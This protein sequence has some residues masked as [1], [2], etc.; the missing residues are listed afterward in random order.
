M[1]LTFCPLNQRAEREATILPSWKQGTWVD[2]YELVSPLV[3]MSKTGETPMSIAGYAAHDPTQG[4]FVLLMTLDPAADEKTRQI[5]EQIEQ[6]RAVRHSAVQTVYDKIDHQGV[7]LYVMEGPDAM[8]CEEWRMPG[9]AAWAKSYRPE[10]HWRYEEQLLA[11]L[12]PVV[13][14]LAKLE[15]AS[16]T[17]PVRVA[18]DGSANG[19][20]S[21]GLIFDPV[22]GSVT[23]DERRTVLS[24][25]VVECLRT[26]GRQVD[27]FPSVQAAMRLGRTFTEMRDDLIRLTVEPDLLQWLREQGDPT[28]GSLGI[29]LER[30]FRRAAKYLP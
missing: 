19:R 28:P 12:L 22:E 14:A 3:P 17:L 2:R 8:T 27:D 9:A 4:R 18:W 20:Y 5:F 25:H 11:L 26:I 21:L 23:S 1:L 7:T 29:K 30:L 10:L 15:Q 13:S 16:V 24:K 6:L